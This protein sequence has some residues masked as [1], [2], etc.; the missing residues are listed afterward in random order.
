MNSALSQA[1]K[2]AR[3]VHDAALALCLCW[4]LLLSAMFT[5]RVMAEEEVETPA[6]Q[7]MARSCAFTRSPLVRTPAPLVI[8]PQGRA[9]NRGVQTR[10]GNNEQSKLNVVGSYLLI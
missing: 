10:H 4:G 9:I 1:K 6:C 5:P 8:R 7:C 2:N 3:R